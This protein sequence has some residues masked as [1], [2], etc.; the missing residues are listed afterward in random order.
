MKIEGIEHIGIVVSDLDACIRTFEEVF[1]VKCETREKVEANKVE[2]AV[3]DFGNTRIELVTPTDPASPVSKFLANR[4]NG[5]HHVCLRVQD[6]EGCLDSLRQRG[7]GLIDKVP[8]HG[9]S[10]RSVAFLSPKS[11]CNVLVELS[12]RK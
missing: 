4:G 9:A 8:R 2:V 12:E 11:V 10:G 6:I 5:I 3:F 7:V 1:G